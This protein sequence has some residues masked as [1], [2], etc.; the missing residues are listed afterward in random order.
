M[1]ALTHL[2]NLA[3][4]LAPQAAPFA[5]GDVVEAH[6]SWSRW[7]VRCGRCP[8]AEQLF[9]FVRGIYD[10]P[11]RF[12]CR[13]CGSVTE[14]I[15]PTEDMARGVERLLMMRPD[16]STRSWFPGETLHDLLIENAAHGVFDHLPDEPVPG[17]TMFAVDDFAIRVDN[18]PRRLPVAPQ[19]PRPEIGS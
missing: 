12:T 11:P 8:S 4:A 15:W 18:L 13:D 3:A 14:I 7:C 1:T 6:A 5:F 19:Q 2:E 16:P 10:P 17:A 9:P